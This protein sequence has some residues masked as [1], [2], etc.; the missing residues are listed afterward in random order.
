MSALNIADRAAEDPA[1][2][3]CLARFAPH[4]NHESPCIGHLLA[5]SSKPAG[6][7][8]GEGR[9]GVL[10]VVLMLF[11]RHPGDH[12]KDVVPARYVIAACGIMVGGVTARSPRRHRP[13]TGRF[14]RNYSGM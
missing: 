11:P 13:V 3:R 4:T 14:I 7:E 1:T 6:V 9:L 5:E 2:A 8:P 12:W 10:G